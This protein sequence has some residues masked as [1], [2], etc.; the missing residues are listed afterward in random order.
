MAILVACGTNGAGKSS[1]VQPYLAATGGAYFNPDDYTR[2]LVKAGL[3][4]QDANGRAWQ[5]GFEQLVTA[6]DDDYDYAF[7]TTLGGHAIAL[8]L[9]RALAMKRELILLYV[10]L[11]SVDLHLRRVR[12]RVARGGH[13]IAEEAIRRRY[14]DSR[15]NLMWFIGTAATV[16]VWDNSVHSQDGRPTGAREV[17]TVRGG[18]LKASQKVESVPAWTTALV[19][20][21]RRLR[22]L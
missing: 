4:Q 13:D 7:E 14:E 12:E 10:G 16:R 20:R 2:A 6:I 8:Q 18:R 22:L 21:A 15:K 1:I 3:S 17:F 9:M 19:A 11:D 5:R